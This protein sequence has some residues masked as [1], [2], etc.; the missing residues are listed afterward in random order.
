MKG[1]RF[2]MAKNSYGLGRLEGLSKAV[3]FLTTNGFIA[4]EGPMSILRS[5]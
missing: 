2:P 5:V 4:P 1:G 3:K